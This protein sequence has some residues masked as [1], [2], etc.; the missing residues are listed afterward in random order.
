MEKRR[1]TLRKE[2]NAVSENII[3]KLEHLRT[4]PK[5]MTPEDFLGKEA[6]GRMIWRIFLLHIWQHTQYPI[7]DQHVYRAM[8]FM[9]TRTIKELPDDCAA[10]QQKYITEY[11]SE[12]HTSELQSPC[13]L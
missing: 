4:L 9:K 3:A 6:K 13:N 11:R 5:D 7:F 2:K 1:G 12:E 10:K 8:I